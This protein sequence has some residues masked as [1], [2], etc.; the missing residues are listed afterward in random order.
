MPAPVRLGGS[1]SIRTKGRGSTTRFEL[2]TPEAGF[3]LDA[4]PG[5]GG[6]EVSVGGKTYKVS[7]QRG[8]EQNVYTVTINGREARARVEESS[9]SHITLSV[10]GQRF[11][12]SRPH[13]S[14]R[15][16]KDQT[17]RETQADASAL[18]SPMP[19]RVISVIA[20]GGRAV[21]QGDP[22][23]IIESMKMESVIKSPRAGSIKDVL[24]KEG[25][26]VRRG[27]ALVRYS[28]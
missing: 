3:D 14:I 8:Q 16:Q 9:E 20:R 28:G 2:R 18:T 21:K 1:T 24:V 11:T 19:G 22:L 13:A 12:F 25:E 4:R 10:R 27:Q 23:V 5:G 7:L 6:L 17:T 26:P 15:F